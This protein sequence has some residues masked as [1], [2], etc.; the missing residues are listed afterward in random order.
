MRSSD[1]ARFGY[2]IRPDG[3]GWAWVT[4]DLTGA[5]AARGW[6][7][8]KT[9]AAACVIRVLAHAAADAGREAA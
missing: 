5:V 4:F 6:A 8:N 2:Q 1:E 7:P 9:L 3:D